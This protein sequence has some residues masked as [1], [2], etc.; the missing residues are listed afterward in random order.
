VETIGIREIRSCPG[1]GGNELETLV[2][3]SE[4]DGE[5]PSHR[6]YLLGAK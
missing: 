1:I 6:R 2:S 4:L 5:D 3:I